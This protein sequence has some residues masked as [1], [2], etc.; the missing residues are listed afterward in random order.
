MLRHGYSLAADHVPRQLR[1]DGPFRA[2]AL[3]NVLEEVAAE[4]MDDAAFAA[5]QS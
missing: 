1:D 5:V 4:Y 3:H 2:S